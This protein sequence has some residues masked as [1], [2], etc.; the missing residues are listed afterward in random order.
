MKHSERRPTLGG[1]SA[2]LSKSS[3]YASELDA[4]T[5]LDGLCYRTRTALA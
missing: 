1:A 2:P 5:P 3:Q 4:R